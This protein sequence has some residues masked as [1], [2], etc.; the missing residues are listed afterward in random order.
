MLECNSYGI[1][2]V[3]VYYWKNAASA[4]TISWLF[5]PS[6]KRGAFGIDKRPKGPHNS[7]QENII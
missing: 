1:S 3:M 7:K 2:N 4:S 5:S 6:L